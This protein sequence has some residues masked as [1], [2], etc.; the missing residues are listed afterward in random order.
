MAVKDLTILINAKDE[1]S[2]TL[3]GIENTLKKLEPQ[4]KNISKIGAVGFTALSA[5]IGKTVKDAAEMQSVSMSFERLSKDLGAS[6]DDVLA[7]LN[8]V[9]K[10]TIANKDIMLSVN[11]AVALGVGENMDD[12]AKLMEIARVKG[13]ALGL[14]TTQAFN[15]MVTGIGRG[16]PLILDNLGI[17]TKGWAEEASALGVAMDAQFI[18]NKIIEDGSVE[19]ANMGEV[20]LTPQERLQQMSKQF[21]DLSAGIGE[22]FLPI[23]QNVLDAVLPVIQTFAEWVKNNQELVK[24]IV[25]IAGGILGVMAV[26]YPLLKVVTTM[27]SLFKMVGVVIGALSSP[28]GLVMLAL[29]ALVAFG[30]VV[31]NNWDSIV[32]GIRLM[33]EGLLE[34]FNIVGEFIMGLWQRIFDFFNV[35]GTGI[36]AGWQRV[37]DFFSASIAW[38]KDVANKIGEWFGKVFESL[39]EVIK[40]AFKGAVNWVIDKLNWLIKKFNDLVIGGINLIPGVNIGKI[41]SI[42]KLADGGIV[43]KPTLALIGE[44][45]PEAVVPLSKGGNATGSTYNIYLNGTYLD[46]QAGEKVGDLIIKRLKLSNAL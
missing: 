2:K 36:M 10:G 35:I 14:D 40:N 32:A 9:S 19:L 20:L 28:I 11:K 44:A 43:T 42:P 39:G 25:L 34:F 27:I 7:K 13:S 37:F 3:S 45:G 17:I 30:W 16:S 26:A 46:K 24:N 29:V 33:W 38:F 18:M 41:A 4:F 8:D 15:D 21:K 1:A 12:L 22:V 31:Y 5:G 23:M 6:G